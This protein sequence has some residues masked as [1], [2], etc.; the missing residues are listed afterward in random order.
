MMDKMN[1]DPRRA[2][3]KPKSH[4]AYRQYQMLYNVWRSMKSNENILK[5]L[6]KAHDTKPGENDLFEVDMRRATKQD[7]KNFAETKQDEEV[8][9]QYQEEDEEM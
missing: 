3:D 8:Q 9:E 1:T 6:Q 5:D 7:I 4:S 2:F